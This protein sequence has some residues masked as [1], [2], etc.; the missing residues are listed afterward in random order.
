MNEDSLKTTEVLLSLYDDDW[1]RELPIKIF[2]Y[3]DG[4]MDLHRQT[5]SEFEAA[6]AEAQKL[7]AA[8]G[9]KAAEVDFI[10]PTGAYMTISKL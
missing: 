2:T 1:R 7:L 6:I 4:S 10:G 3:Q 8:R 5:S 9:L